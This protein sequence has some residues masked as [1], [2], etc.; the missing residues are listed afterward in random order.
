MLAI[1]C[2]TL[3]DWVNGV[4]VH[5]QDQVN[6]LLTFL[7]FTCGAFLIF[8]WLFPRGRRSRL[9][10]GVILDVNPELLLIAGAVGFIAALVNWYVTTGGSMYSD[11][12][13][14]QWLVKIPVITARMWWPFMATYPAAFVSAYLIPSDFIHPSKQRRTIRFTLG[15]AI[16]AG[17][18]WSSGTGGRQALGIV[19][20]HALAGSA[21]GL[22][23]TPG[24]SAS[25][26]LLRTL[27]KTAI[28]AL[29]LVVVLAVVAEVTGR[30]RAE[31]LGAPQ[32]SS[33]AGVPYLGMVSVFVH[34]MAGSIATYQ[35]YGPAPRRD[36]SKTGPVSLAAIQGL[37]VGYVM[38]WRMPRKFDTNPERAKPWLPLFSGARC[39]FYDFVADFGFA[40]AMIVVT[41]LV[42][43]SQILFSLTREPRMILSAAPLVMML[44]F[45]GYSHQFSLLMYN[46]LTWLIISF[47]LWDLVHNS[48]PRR[49]RHSLVGPDVQPRLPAPAGVL[50]KSAPRAKH[51]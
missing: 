25:R 40:H 6:E 42:L 51:A 10:P 33:F 5:N 4:P 8:A 18:F 1:G 21:L 16:A 47:G 32:S 35:A 41:V 14:Q 44:M 13:R 2:Y 22:R 50:L 24:R 23:F 48:L 9:R 31:Q 29:S 43:L 20:L 12:V 36:L 34:Y 30:M 38:G 49:R 28:V 27:T 39:V 26:P 3:V 17:L 45:W 7:V 19:I 11:A 37:G 46:P 15:L